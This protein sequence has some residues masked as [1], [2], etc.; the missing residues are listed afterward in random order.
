MSSMIDPLVLFVPPTV[1]PLHGLAAAQFF[2]NSNTIWYFRLD[3]NMI[4]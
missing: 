3:A 1:Y 2:K 4:V